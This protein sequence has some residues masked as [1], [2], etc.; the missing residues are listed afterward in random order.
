MTRL[1]DTRSTRAW[2]SSCALRAFF[3]VLLL[4]LLPRAAAAQGEGGNPANWCRNGL[5]AADAGEFG[6][7]RVVGGRGERAYFYGDEEGCPGPAAKCRQ[8]AYVLTG[9]ELIV[10]RRFG[11]W[12]CAWY[13]P[14]RGSETV[15]WLP[16]SRL[17]LTTADANPPLASWLG[18]WEFYDDSLR[19][20]RG[21]K[22]GT[23]G[24]GGDATWVGVNPG[25]VHVGEV[26]GEAAPSG[27]LLS[28]G[29]DPD[30]CR[31]KLRLVGPFLIVNDNKQCGG[32]NVTFDG[33]YRRKKR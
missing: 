28:L 7:A 14:A 21:R 11:D 13:Q 1:N 23:L 15:G 4:T 31:V 27:N 29:E 17:E 10:S 9:D 19:I 12:V 30:D 33:V 26:S 8:K 3:F 5:F 20:T 24:V 32:A 18:T 6:L 22:A 2:H 25:N 16:A